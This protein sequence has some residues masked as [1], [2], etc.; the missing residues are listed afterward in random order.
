MVPG[1]GVHAAA[2]AHHPGGGA[3][4]CPADT[5]N[6]GGEGSGRSLAPPLPRSPTLLSS[7]PGRPSAGLCPRLQLG[8]ARRCNS[9]RTD[10]VIPCVLP[11][12]P[13]NPL[14][15]LPLRSWC[16]GLWRRAR[17]GTPTPGQPSKRSW[18]RC[19]PAARQLAPPLP[20]PVPARH[21]PPRP[22]L[23]RRRLRAPRLAPCDQ[24]LP[25]AGAALQN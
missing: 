4:R 16:R 1:P 7:I 9:V 17:S 10:I 23:R 2:A 18:P 14:S 20:R 3:A 22:R 15:P 12:S 6:S 11:V 13:P 25:L 21:R 24:G 8:L 5:G 19:A